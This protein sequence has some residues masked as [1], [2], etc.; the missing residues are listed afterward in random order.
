MVPYEVMLER[1]AGSTAVYEEVDPYEMMLEQVCAHLPR[2][3]GWHVC[4]GQ[5]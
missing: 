5:F 1:V 4:V 3:C 2:L